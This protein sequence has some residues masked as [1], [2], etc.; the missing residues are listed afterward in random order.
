MNFGRIIPIDLFKKKIYK[1]IGKKFKNITILDIGCRWYNRE[2]KNNIANST[3]KYIQM[4]PDSNENTQCNRNPKYNDGFQECTVED[5]LKKYPQLVNS[6][7]IILDFGVL[8]A[9]SIAKNIDKNTYI[10]NIYKM[11]KTN[12]I[13]MLKIDNDDNWK[14]LNDR[15][16]IN[17]DQDIYPRFKKGSISDFSDTDKI[18]HYEFFLFRKL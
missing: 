11:L 12:G 16:K 17:L 1:R 18:D 2:T 9:H 5:S 6:F 7:D 10:E 3:I 13:Y 15:H 4:D 14:N 8:G